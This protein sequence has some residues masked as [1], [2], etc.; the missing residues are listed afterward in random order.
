[1]KKNKKEEA[2]KIA[3]ALFFSVVVVVACILYRDSKKAEKQKSEDEKY[4]KSFAEYILNAAKTEAMADT[5]TLERLGVSYSSYPVA[6]LERAL[7]VMA[8]DSARCADSIVNNA[9]LVLGC[10]GQDFDKVLN[11]IKSK[12]P[13]SIYTKDV[14]FKPGDKMSNFAVY[15]EQ[16]KQCLKLLAAVR[17]N[18]L[19]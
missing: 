18:R 19:R 14:L 12:R 7:D 11:T 10:R 16:Y 3:K 1:M 17:N 4:T 8:S 9:D 2:K 13:I 5:A 15:Y 6:E